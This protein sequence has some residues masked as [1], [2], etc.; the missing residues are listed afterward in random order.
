L[1]AKVTIEEA[2][3]G[4]SPLNVCNISG[5]LGS[6]PLCSFTIFCAIPCSACARLLYPRPT[7]TFKTSLK[8]AFAKDSK[9][10]KV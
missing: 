6:A 2:V 9:V 8:D 3:A 5:Q 7:Q 1:K 10:G 4:P